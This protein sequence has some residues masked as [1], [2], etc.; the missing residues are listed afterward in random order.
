MLSDTISHIERVIGEQTLFS[1]ALNLLFISLIAQLVLAHF[2]VHGRF[3][4]A[5]AWTGVRKEWLPKIRAKFR[6]IGGIRQMLSDGYE[7]FSKQKK[8]FVLPMIAEEPW[9]VLPPSSI[10][11]LLAKSDSE[12]DMK[13]IHEEQL[14]HKYTTG[15]LGRHVVDV[16]IQYDILHRQVNRKLP[17]LIDAFYDEL[18][19][20]F[21]QHWGT[22]M[23]YTEVGVSATCGKIITQ[24]LNR[25]FAGQEICRDEDFLKHSKL[26]SEGVGSSAIIV[27]MLP[28]PL[29]PLLAPL[30]TYSNRKHH[31]I[32]MRV[33]LP[34]IIDRLQHTA[35]KRADA[36]YL[37]EPPVDVLQWII[38]ECFERN[39]PKE[40]DAHM[41]TQRLL[42]LNFVAVETTHMSMAHTIL[43][44]YRSPN[45]DEFVAGLRQECD[46]VLEA[47]DGQWTKSGLDDLVCVDSTIR[48]SMRYS[49]LGYIA[50][51]RMVVDPHGTQFSVN[52]INSS[53]PLTVPPGIRVCVPAHAIHRDATLNPS[54]HEFQAFRFAK[55]REKDGQRETKLSEP[56]VSIVTTTDKFLPFGHGRHACPG[57]FFAAQQMKL[58]LAY[59][60]QNYDVEK[61]STKVEN[62]VM[63]GTATPD[64]KLKVR[65]KRRK[66]YA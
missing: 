14:L 40:L 64:A 38:D 21:R 35:A 2:T 4:N 66:G 51:T 32:C 10:P 18:D 23:S 54:P 53:S 13:I 37:W 33:C 31:D 65:V 15:S 58:M 41:I 3:W 48:E 8:A 43:D 22:D 63:V 49:D 50:L 6:S 26:Y 30:I 55:S 61:L 47:N 1:G 16:P 17:L 28:R 20:S 62:K 12:V 11:E 34:V 57:R 7:G 42:K 27:R 52:G 25:I 9:L 24:A 59:L 29:Q 5:Q 39:D 19:H 46:S 60:V 56:K 36:G 45:S 44:L